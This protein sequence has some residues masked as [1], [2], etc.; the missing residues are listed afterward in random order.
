MLRAFVRKAF[1]CHHQIY[2][3]PLRQGAH[4]L[5]TKP[6]GETQADVWGENQSTQTDLKFLGVLGVCLPLQGA[7]HSR[8]VNAFAF[9]LAAEV[10]LLVILHLNQGISSAVSNTGPMIL[11]HYYPCPCSLRSLS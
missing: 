4:P 3:F 1:H 10:Q 6:L 5:G 9:C 2:G 11:Y 8:A 7:V